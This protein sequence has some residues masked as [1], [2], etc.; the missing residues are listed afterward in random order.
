MIYRCTHC[1]G[2]FDTGEAR[3]GDRC[4]SCASGR[5]EVVYRLTERMIAESEVGPI[6]V[7]EGWR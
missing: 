1:R 6:T 5:W 2:L 3:H 4:P 7:P